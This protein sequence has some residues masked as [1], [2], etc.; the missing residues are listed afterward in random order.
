MKPKSS[1]L[2]RRYAAA[3]L[4][5]LQNV[6]SPDLKAARELGGK[7]VA[8]GL[9]AMYLARVHEKI[10]AGGV[11]LDGP[12]AKRAQRIKQAGRFF[13]AVVI[14]IEKKHRTAK[15][16]TEEL[17]EFA[18]MLSQRTIELAASHL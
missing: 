10:V 3:L 8:A 6:G 17:E 7:A 16:A 5:H 4:A 9:S 11:F 18:E 2:S 12:P 13:G 15:S 14:P 1:T